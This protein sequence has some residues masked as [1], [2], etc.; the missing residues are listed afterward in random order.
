MLLLDDDEALPEEPLQSSTFSLHPESSG[1]L[2][3][4]DRGA[5]HA[6]PEKF[7][8]RARARADD[9]RRVLFHTVCPAS[10][11]GSG[12]G[13]ATQ[14]TVEYSPAPRSKNAQAAARPTS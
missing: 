4:A 2:W 9:G 3:P 13:S 6:V 1:A 11:G 10:W 12:D 8:A 5:A 7:H 14:P